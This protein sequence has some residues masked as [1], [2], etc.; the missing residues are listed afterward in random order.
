MQENTTSVKLG[1]K[2]QYMGDSKQQNCYF[3]D[4]K[5]KLEMLS[6]K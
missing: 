5:S 4:V 6:G 2:R 1:K 3:R